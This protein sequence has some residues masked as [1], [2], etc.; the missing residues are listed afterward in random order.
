[1]LSAEIAPDPDSVREAMRA[2]PRADAD[3]DLELALVY[4][5][6]VVGEFPFALGLATRVLER[7]PELR[8]AAYARVCAHIAL[9]DRPAAAEAALSWTSAKGPDPV[10]L[11]RATGELPRP[12]PWGAMIDL[13]IDSDRALDL[14]AAFGRARG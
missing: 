11:A 2:L 4:L 1:M 3:P 12:A 8:W 9:E 10:M 5:S 6:F 13:R 7:A 14:A